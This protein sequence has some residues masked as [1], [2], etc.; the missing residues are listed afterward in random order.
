MKKIYFLLILHG[1]FAFSQED[2]KTIPE[3]CDNPCGPIEKIE[4]RVVVDDSLAQM[5][6]YNFVIHQTFNRLFGTYS[7]TSSFIAPDV[8]ITA[9]HNVK[10]KGFIQ[11]ITFH[12]PID[13]S[14]TIYF[15]KREFTIYYY[16]S[17]LGVSSDIALIKFKDKTKI[18]PF[19]YGSFQ[20][21]TF[22]TITS[23]TAQVHLTGFPCDMSDTKMDK[24][25]SYVNILAHEKESL[26]GYNMFTCTGDSGAP[27][28]IMENNIPTLLGIH[29]GGN[30]GYFK[31]CYNISAKI[32]INVQNWINQY[33]NH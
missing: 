31:N 17:K 8:L 33:I 14:Q 2:C 10:N 4:A 24:S 29:H 13:H 26:L 19:Y 7:S 12:N 6:P 16:K 9:H 15:K 23:T 28:W 30:E 27:L 5:K 18:A 3:N 11:G 20:L 32:D 25:D 22:E 21:Q 1:F